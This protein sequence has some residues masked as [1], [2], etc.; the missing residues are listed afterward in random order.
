MVD[1]ESKWGEVWPG[2]KLD[3]STEGFHF[4]DRFQLQAQTSR[5]DPK[6]GCQIWAESRPDWQQM[7]QIWNMNY[8]DQISSHQAKINILLK[9]HGFVRFRTNLTHFR[10]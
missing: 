8:L 4:T 1:L 2:E 6:H 5:Q 10:P 7:G 9:S 3:L